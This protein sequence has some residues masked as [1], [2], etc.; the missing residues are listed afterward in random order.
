MLGICVV[1]NLVAVH[2]R[3]D[4]GLLE[5]LG[6]VDN[7]QDDIRS[8]GFPFMCFEEGG[9]A[10]GRL[11]SPVALLLDALVLVGSSVAVGIA[12]AHLRGRGE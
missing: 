8:I 7:W 3:S 4:G 9:Y 10:G 2:L 5:G 11:F 1:A 6:V 12:Y